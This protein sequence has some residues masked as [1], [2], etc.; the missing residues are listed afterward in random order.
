MRPSAGSGAGSQARCQSATVFRYFSWFGC[1]HGGCPAGP[2]PKCQRLRFRWRQWQLFL[3]SARC[4]GV[5]RSPV[6][7]GFWC[8]LRC[9][10]ILSIQHV[11]SLRNDGDERGLHP[12]EI[13]SRNMC[14]NK[15]YEGLTF[16]C[17]KAVPKVPLAVV[18]PSIWRG[19]E[20][21][22]PLPASCGR[23][24]QRHFFFFRLVYP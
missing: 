2:A 5:P 8:W 15:A 16:V 6:A 21:H 20:C 3:L 4:C 14:L 9:P 13:Q 11:C 22:L 23:A 19:R 24:S 17:V 7:L 1:M 18:A 12:H 10:F